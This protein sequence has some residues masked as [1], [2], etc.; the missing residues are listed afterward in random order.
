[1]DQ[2][3][4]KICQALGIDG[5]LNGTDLCA[6]EA[7]L[8]VEEG[9]RVPDECVTIGPRVGLNSVPEPWKSMPWRFQVKE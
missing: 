9:D 7:V 4:R 5:G 3:P 6:G 8:F 2:R 1:M